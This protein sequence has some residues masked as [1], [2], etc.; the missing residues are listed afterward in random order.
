[1]KKTGTHLMDVFNKLAAD[2]ATHFAAKLTLFANIA[3]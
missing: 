3:V 2:Y 1:L